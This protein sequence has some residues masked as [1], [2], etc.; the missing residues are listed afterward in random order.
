MLSAMAHVA[1]GSRCD[2][3]FRITPRVV[4]FIKTVARIPS[5]LL[6]LERARSHNMDSE[7]GRE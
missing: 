4:G 1:Q 6:L 3:L 7:E 2:Y 5:R